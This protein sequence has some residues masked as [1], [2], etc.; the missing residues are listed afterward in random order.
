VV[1]PAGDGANAAINISVVLN[2]FQELRD[3]FPS[4]Q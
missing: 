1:K 3:R 4:R 2:W